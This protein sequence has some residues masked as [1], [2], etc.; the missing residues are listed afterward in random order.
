MSAL[1]QRFFIVL[2][3]LTVFTGRIFIYAMPLPKATKEIFKS[4]AGDSS[5]KSESSE[6]QNQLEDKDKLADLLLIRMNEVDF[7][8]L[9]HSI[10]S[11]FHGMFNLIHCHLQIPEQPPK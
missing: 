2:I 4:S 7:N 11:Q 6:K 5:E 8:D 3:L 10:N 9:H 1:Y